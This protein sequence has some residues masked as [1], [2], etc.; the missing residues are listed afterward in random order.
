MAL[1][2]HVLILLLWKIERTIIFLRNKNAY[3]PSKM[4]VNITFFKYLFKR[5]RYFQVVTI[6]YPIDCSYNID[7]IILKLYIYWGDCFAIFSFVLIL[8]ICT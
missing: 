4:C 8:F 1:F 5:R 7:N 6:C 2:Y 3:L